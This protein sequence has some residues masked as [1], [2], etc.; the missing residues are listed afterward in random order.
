MNPR[1]PSHGRVRRH[2]RTRR[3]RLRPGANSRPTAGREAGSEA[4]PV[5]TPRCCVHCHQTTNPDAPGPPPRGPSEASEP[6]P[7]H[8]R[9][10][11]ARRREVAI[12]VRPP[13]SG[14]MVSAAPAVAGAPNT[15]R[16]SP[17]SRRVRDER[18]LA[19]ARLVLV[20]ASSKAY[21]GPNSAATAPIATRPPFLGSLG[22]TEGDARCPCVSGAAARAFAHSAPRPVAPSPNFILGGPRHLGSFFALWSTAFRRLALGLDSYSCGY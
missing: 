22:P 14:S 8:D 5:C 21:Q 10:S 17:P 19:S 9:E 7:T 3:K 13:L 11:Y 1:R 12:I 6:R 16:P 18:G 4:P 15:P 20:G 2:R